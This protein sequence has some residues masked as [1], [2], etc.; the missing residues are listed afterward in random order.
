MFIESGVPL[1]SHLLSGDSVFISS[2]TSR[3]SQTS[4][5]RLHQ[6]CTALNL[7]EHGLSQS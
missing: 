1:K 4:L 5:F 3:T 6:V 7:L 2:Y